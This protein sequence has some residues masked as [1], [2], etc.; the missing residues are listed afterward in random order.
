MRS[1]RWRGGDN[2]DDAK[3]PREV[4]VVFATGGGRP[5][6]AV[7]SCASRPRRHSALMTLFC[8]FEL[9]DLRFRDA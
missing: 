6:T 4:E 8:G 2:E 5:V 3:A 9:A 7:P 1:P